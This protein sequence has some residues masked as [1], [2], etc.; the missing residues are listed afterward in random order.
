LSFSAPLAGQSFSNF[1]SF[2]AG[3]IAFDAVQELFLFIFT[4]KQ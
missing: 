3:G 4:N 2:M 1:V